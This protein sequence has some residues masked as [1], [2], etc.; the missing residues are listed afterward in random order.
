MNCDDLVRLV[1][2]R[3]FALGVRFAADRKAAGSGSLPKR[4]STWR[5]HLAACGL[6][7]CISI[8][9][10]G[11]GRDSKRQTVSDSSMVELLVEL[12]LA[13]ARV[14]ITDRPLPITRDSI[15]EAYGV[16][17][18]GYARTLEYYAQHPD[19]YSR[20]YGEVLD[21]LSAERRPFDGST[22]P[23]TLPP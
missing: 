4:S 18:A 16:D 21:R 7:L 15:L 8:I 23:D 12:H 22:M 6:A 19:L 5:L 10:A 11:C 2:R 14:E 1:R 13:N 9:S 17:S 3:L 20:I